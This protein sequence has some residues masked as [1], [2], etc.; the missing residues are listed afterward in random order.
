MRLLH[1]MGPLRLVAPP[2]V[3]QEVEEKLETWAIARGLDPNLAR[4]MWEQNYQGSIRFIDP[5]SFSIAEPRVVA[6]SRRDADDVPSA[7]LAILLGRKA[8]SED[9]DLF[10]NGLATGAPWLEIV[11]A[12]GYVAVGETIQAGATGAIG[13]S[14]QGGI[15]TIRSVHA[16][17][18]TP[19]GRQ[20]LTVAAIVLLVVLGA[21][22]LLR[23]VHEPSRRQIDAAATTAVEALKHASQVAIGGYFKADF[24]RRTGEATLAT[25][26]VA[27]SQPVS[28]TQIA[29]RSLA[30]APNPIS[31]IELARHCKHQPIPADGLIELR[32]VLRT[33][34]AFVEATPDCWQ[35]GSDLK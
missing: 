6:L 35:L 27:T 1:N 17:S 34:P 13:V 2:H 7:Q 21:V 28:L 18:L 12:A 15:Q 25:G 32:R 14:A 33:L 30:V 4:Q 9:R 26:V 10:D 5:G 11:F 19:D 16:L 31:S 20:V 3:G 29:A 22:L 23:E 24:N 8:L